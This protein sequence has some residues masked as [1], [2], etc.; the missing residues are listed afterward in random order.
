[1]APILNPT[2]NV[3]LKVCR[4]PYLEHTSV[5]ETI[6]LPSSSLVDFVCSRLILLDLVPF[7]R[8]KMSLG[9]EFDIGEFETFFGLLNW[10]I[11]SNELV[12]VFAPVILCAEALPCHLVEESLL[13]RRELWLQ[14]YSIS[15]C[16]KHFPHFCLFAISLSL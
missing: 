8:V 12:R 1:M 11:F 7:S 4:Q 9:H 15:P 10:E 3:W 6:L 13:H 2:Y 16:V 14:L 5:L